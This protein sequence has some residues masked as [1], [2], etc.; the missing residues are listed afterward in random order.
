MK[1]GQMAG[2]N[3]YISRFNFVPRFHAL[4]KSAERSSNFFS[5]TFLF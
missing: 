1:Q 2:K 5:V 4:I 3:V